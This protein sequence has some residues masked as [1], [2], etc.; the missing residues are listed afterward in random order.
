MLA[1]LLLDLHLR[2]AW[3][4]RRRSPRR[5]VATELVKDP[6][7]V[8]EHVITG[9]WARAALPASSAEQTQAAYAGLR[10]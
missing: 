7:N 2:S 3:S 5:G 6:A 1:G 9:K 4:K 10:G 8:P